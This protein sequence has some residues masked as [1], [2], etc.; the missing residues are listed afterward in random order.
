MGKRK[1]VLAPIGKYETIISKTNYASAK[2]T[3]NNDCLM[4]LATALPLVNA[5]QENSYSSYVTGS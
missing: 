4:F 3:Q 2:H 1:Y 5:V